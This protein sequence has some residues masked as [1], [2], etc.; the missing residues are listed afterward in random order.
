MGEA[1]RRK[2]L[3]LY[4]DDSKPENRPLPVGPTGPA[5]ITRVCESCQKSGGTLVMIEN[6]KYVHSP[7]CQY[8]AAAVKRMQHEQN[9]FSRKMRESLLRARRLLRDGP[10]AETDDE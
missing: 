10:K 9:E 3:G 8:A 2:L 4:P 7:D 6:G 1:K 5:E